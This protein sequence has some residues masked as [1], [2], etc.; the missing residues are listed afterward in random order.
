VDSKPTP[1][2]SRIPMDYIHKRECDTFYELSQAGVLNLPSSIR[3]QMNP[4]HNRAK[5]R[6]T[7]DQKTG[8]VK[9]KIVKVRV[10]DI[11]VF[12]PFTAFD[13]R[14]SVNLEMNFEGDM[15][16]LVEQASLEGKGPDRNKDRVSYKHLYYT[17]D[18]TQVTP[19]DVSKHFSITVSQILTCMLPRLSFSLFVNHHLR[20]NF[21]SYTP[22]RQPPKPKKNTNWKLKFPPTK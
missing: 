1:T 8:E 22:N 18:L 9:A 16:D 17:I 13:W 14:V 5:V 15:R 19:T 21:D 3:A 6:I 4:R 2:K 10:A 12:S 20:A 7:T 11:D